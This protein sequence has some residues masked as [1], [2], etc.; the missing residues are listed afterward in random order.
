MLR[1]VLFFF[2][3][4][5]SHILFA[6]SL[7]IDDLKSQGRALANY[8]TCAELAKDS[9]DKIMQSYY[10]DM[11]ADMSLKVERYPAPK[12]A[13]VNNA[14]QLSLVEFTKLNRKN[15]AVFCGSRLDDLTR[16]MQAKKLDKE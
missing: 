10:S 4:M 15:L 12:S 14:Y 16:K 1:T 9:Q 11:Y 3:V 8:Q 2:C 7:D 13:I 5:T 6:Q